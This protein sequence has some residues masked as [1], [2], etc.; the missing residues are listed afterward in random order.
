LRKRAICHFSTVAQFALN[1]A[2]A[3]WDNTPSIKLFLQQAMGAVDVRDEETD[4]RFPE[5]AVRGL[6]EPLVGSAPRGGM[7]QGTRFKFLLAP[8]CLERA[9]KKLPSHDLRSPQ[10]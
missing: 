4:A 9:A 1:C 10:W 3:S 7:G 6:C 8:G 5:D 2:P